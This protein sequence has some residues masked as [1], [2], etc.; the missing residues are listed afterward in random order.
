MVTV[1]Y[2]DISPVTLNEKIF[3]IF[4]T[5]VATGVFANVVNIIG[6]IYQEKAE[7]TAK[8]K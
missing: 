1:G 8:F 7:K 2:G 5:L 3:C 4:F 6:S